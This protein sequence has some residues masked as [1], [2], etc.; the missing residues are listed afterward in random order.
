MNATLTSSPA[1]HA[2]TCLH[3]VGGRTVEIAHSRGNASVRIA[4]TDD[5]R[6][7]PQAG[8]FAQADAEQAKA[9][10]CLRRASLYRAAAWHVIREKESLLAPRTKDAHGAIPPVSSPLPMRTVVYPDGSIEATNWADRHVADGKARY[11]TAAECADYERHFERCDA[12][13]TLTL[14]AEGSR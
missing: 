1:I 13:A 3:L 14:C 12:A 6:I 8:L 9:R 2:V 4:D 10:E 5:T 11:A 7:T